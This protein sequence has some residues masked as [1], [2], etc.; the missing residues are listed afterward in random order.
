MIKH[1][2][3]IYDNQHFFVRPS[4]ALCFA[5]INYTY[6]Y[7]KVIEMCTGRNNLI[8]YIKTQSALRLST[9]SFHP[10]S[11]FWHNCNHKYFQKESNCD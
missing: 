2:H 11:T 4:Y 7:P 1:K 5:L 6:M 3:I 10:P 8:F 9:A